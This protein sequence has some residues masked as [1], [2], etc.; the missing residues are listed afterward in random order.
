VNITVRISPEGQHLNLDFNLSLQNI[1]RIFCPHDTFTKAVFSLDEI[2]FHAHFALYKSF[3]VF[4]T[5]FLLFH[6]TFLFL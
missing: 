3:V 2:F 5:N 6:Q 1:P 4:D